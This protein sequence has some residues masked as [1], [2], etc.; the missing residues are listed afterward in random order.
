MN[1]RLS[2]DAG[3]RGSM[4]ISSFDPPLQAPPKP[5]AHLMLTPNS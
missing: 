3:V 2:E 5:Q 1:A 4:L